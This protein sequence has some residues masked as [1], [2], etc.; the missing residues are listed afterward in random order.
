MKHAGSN[1]TLTAATAR[2]PMPEI[3][4]LAL[5]LAS[6]SP[7]SRLVL[8]AGCLLLI[9]LVADGPV[10]SLVQTLDPSA[11]AVLRFVTGFGNSA[12]PL[13]IGLF[14][15]GLVEALRRFDPPLLTD[16]VRGVR[17]VLVFVVA[18][19][20]ISGFLASLSKHVIGRIRP[21]TDPGAMVFD[22][23]VMAFKTGWA[24]FPSGHATTATAAAVALALCFPRFA[25]AWA[26]VGALA[27]LSRALLGVHWLTDCLAGIVLGT[28]VTL[29][30]H[31]RMSAAGH[32]LEM[33]SGAVAR[34]ARL[35][36]AALRRTLADAWA[37]LS[38]ARG[39]TDDTPRRL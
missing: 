29:E 37:R 13:G 3:R 19:V 24:A 6:Q 30:I 39:R 4:P 26:T 5:G 35:C 23:S 1:E 16:D 2:P 33:K 12:W 10:R 17:S 9:A 34:A 11:H 18:S 21:S 8:V 38:L 20:A 14:L 36:A 31:R 22:F 27:A 25:W 15:L 28:V 32:L 7:A